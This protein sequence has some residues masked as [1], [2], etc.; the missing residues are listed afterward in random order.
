LD[1]VSSDESI[2]LILSWAVVALV[3]LLNEAESCDSDTRHLD[4]GI[5]RAGALAGAFLSELD[6]SSAIKFRRQW[7]ICAHNM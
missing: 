6:Q 1:S 5:D 2:E 3:S 4:A 7:S